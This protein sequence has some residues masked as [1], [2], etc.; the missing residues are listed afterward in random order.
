VKG[1]SKKHFKANKRLAKGKR[2]NPED[3]DY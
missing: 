2:N 3:D 1:N